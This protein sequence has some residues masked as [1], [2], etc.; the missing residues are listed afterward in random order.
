MGSLL[1]GRFVEVLFISAAFGAIYRLPEFAL[2]AV[3]K[4]ACSIFLLKACFRSDS[5]SDQNVTLPWFPRS[6]LRW[7]RLATIVVL[8][9]IPSLIQAAEAAAFQRQVRVVASYGQAL[10]NAGP[11]YLPEHQALFFTSNRLRRA[12]GSPYVVVSLF[13]VNSGR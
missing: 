2:S 4:S 11:I 1:L 6:L 8:C 5:L 13:D 10:A 7:R 12:D 9:V 3:Q